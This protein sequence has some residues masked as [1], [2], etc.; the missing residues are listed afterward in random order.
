M[1]KVL[2]VCLGNIC[3]SP[4]AEGIFSQLV[5]SKGLSDKVY[6]DSAGTSG[7]HSGSAP[8][9]RSQAAAKKRNID[10]SNQ[11]SRIVT[12]AD[13]IRFDYIVAMDEQNLQD[14][15]TKYKNNV[16]NNFSMLLSYAPQLG[17][18]NVPDPY[19]LGSFDDV[20]DMIEVACEALFI[21]ICN[22]YN[23]EV[24]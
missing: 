8:D 3:R 14:L 23:F 10:I 24:W 5:S 19:Y 11:K 4:T 17:Q 12:T 22:A 18:T 13:L 20:F 15:R 16:N 21:E 2:F 1:V 7:W 9:Q 6:T